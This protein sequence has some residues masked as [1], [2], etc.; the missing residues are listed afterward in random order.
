M[1]VGWSL[2]FLVISSHLAKECH[3]PQFVAGRCKSAA[4][5]WT[6]ILGP[7]LQLD[8]VSTSPARSVQIGDFMM[9]VADST[10]RE[11]RRLAAL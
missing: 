11:L 8:V 3:F 9:T 1:A 6:R 5:T 10:G 7:L 2:L 4:P